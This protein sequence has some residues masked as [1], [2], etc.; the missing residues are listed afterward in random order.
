[1][2]KRL[3]KTLC[4]VVLFVVFATSASLVFNPF[5]GKLDYVGGSTSTSITIN[6][7]SCTLGS[8]CTLPVTNTIDFT[9]D[10]GGAALSGSAKTCKLVAS[11]AT[12]TA[13][14]L[15]SEAAT[16]DA[17]AGSDTIQLGT[18]TYANWLTSTAPSNL[19]SAVSIS[20]ATGAS[21][22]GLSGAITANTMLCASLSSPSATVR[23]HVGVVTTTP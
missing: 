17:L 1:M 3:Y 8:T 21:S 5:T 20:S 7:V 12:V 16:G 6:G 19:G 23:L 10:G 22:T 18:V 14:Y 15:T 4:G 11:A 9:F 13:I 2:L